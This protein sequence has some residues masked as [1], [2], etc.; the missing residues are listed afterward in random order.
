LAD[1]SDYGVVRSD[2]TE[3]NNLTTK[4]HGAKLVPRTA[5]AGRMAQTA[6]LPDLIGSMVSLLRNRL[7]K[8]LTRF[9]DQ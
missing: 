3:L 5:V 2:I 7:D 1:L 9:M 6:T 8:Q 4:F